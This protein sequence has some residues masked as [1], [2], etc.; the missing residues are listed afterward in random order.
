LY[1]FEALPE[2]VMFVSAYFSLLKDISE[3][4]GV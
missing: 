1:A 2:Q 4:F 3:M